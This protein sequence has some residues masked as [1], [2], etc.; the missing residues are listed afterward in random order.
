MESFVASPLLRALD[1]KPVQSLRELAAAQGRSA[2]AEHRNIVAKRSG[3]LARELRR[4]ADE[5]P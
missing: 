3:V 5:H 2:E 4:S 1:G